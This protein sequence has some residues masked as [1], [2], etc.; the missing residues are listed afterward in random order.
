M[1]QPCSAMQ[2][3]PRCRYLRSL[4]WTKINQHLLP[5]PTLG[6]S[7]VGVLLRFREHPI[8]VSGD[9]KEIF[10]Q[11]HFLPEDRLLLRFLLRG[12]KVDEPPRVFSGR[13]CP[14][15][16][17][18]APVVLRMRSSA[19]WLNTASLKT[20]CGSLSNIAFMSITANS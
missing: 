6:A 14:S 8:A 9:I 4:S 15:A 12:L 1:L 16:Q 19:M 5:G 13:S 10:H 20:P 3:C 18:V 7:L 2:P 17:P 11:I